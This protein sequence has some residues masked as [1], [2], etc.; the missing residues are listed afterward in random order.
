MKTAVVTVNGHTLWRGP[1]PASEAELVA[2]KCPIII[3]LE[4]GWFEFLHGEVHQEFEW[5]LK[6]GIFL[7]HYPMSDF[8]AP[9]FVK[10]RQALVAIT[11]GLKT[12]DVYLHCLHGEDRTGF[13]CAAYRMVNQNWTYDQATAE[14]FSL[15][16]HKIPYLLWLPELKKYA[17][18]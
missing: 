10:V 15:G 3:N 11:G 6:N 12:G 17:S 5:T 7:F 18:K 13:V 8:R 16:F 9:S 4:E 1:R 2:L 14:M